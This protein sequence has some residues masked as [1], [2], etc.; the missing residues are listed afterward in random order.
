MKT[1]ESAYILGIIISVSKNVILLQQGIQYSHFLY[2]L[3]Y[4]AY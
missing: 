1:A 3:L 4:T 2:I